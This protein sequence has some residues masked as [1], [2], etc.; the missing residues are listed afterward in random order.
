MRGGACFQDRWSWR[1]DTHDDWPLTIQRDRPD[2]WNV[3][4]TAKRVYGDY[5]SAFLCFM[6]VCLPEMHRVLRGYGSLYPHCDQTASHY[7]KSLLDAIF[8][9]VNFRTV[10]QA[11]DRSPGSIRRRNVWKRTRLT[12]SSVPPKLAG[13]SSVPDPVEGRTQG[14]RSTGPR[15]SGPVPRLRSADNSRQTGQRGGS[16]GSSPSIPNLHSDLYTSLQFRNITQGDRLIRASRS[17]AGRWI[18]ST[19]EKAVKADAIP[20]GAAQSRQA[21]KL[22]HRQE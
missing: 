9:K 21:E 16:P 10:L 11:A 13:V 19:A 6:A 4:D 22:T 7:L 17:T 20:A 2:V 15:N 12:H 14:I 18:Q 8:G 3:P 5:I 1:D